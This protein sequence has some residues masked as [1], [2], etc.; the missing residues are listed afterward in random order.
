MERKKGQQRV[1]RRRPRTFLSV[2]VALIRYFMRRVL[3]AEDSHGKQG[4]MH[5][6]MRGALQGYY[7]DWKFLLGFVWVSFRSLSQMRP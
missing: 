6:Q 5:G 3:A 2:R 1:N 4:H 7:Y